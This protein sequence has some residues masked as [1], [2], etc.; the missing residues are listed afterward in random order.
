MLINN[1]WKYCFN[2]GLSKS[3]NINQWNL[4]RCRIDA[5]FFVEA[6]WDYSINN[7][8][9]D[10][11]TGKYLIKTRNINEIGNGVGFWK[12]I[13]ISV[14]ILVISEFFINYY[15]YV[16]FFIFFYKYIFCSRIY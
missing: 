12:T 11:S 9:A 1:W 16:M 8:S 2:K 5:N 15:I 3:K 7:L 13:P 14:L 10:R 6:I 4:G